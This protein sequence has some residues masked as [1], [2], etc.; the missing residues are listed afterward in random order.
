MPQAATYLPDDKDQIE[1]GINEMRARAADIA[2]AWAYYYGDQTLPLKI[3]PVH[4]DQNVIMNLVGQAADDLVAMMGIPRFEVPGGSA[5]EPDEAGHLR[6]S[7]SDE[8]MW[9]DDWWEAH[10]LAEFMVDLTL[11]GM[12]AGHNYIRLY[13]DGDDGVPQAALLD[14]A[15]VV[16]FWD[17]ANKTRALWYRQQ[18]ATADGGQRMQDIVRGD[19]VRSESGS[20]IAPWVII[21]YA[22]SKNSSRWEW[23]ATDPWEFDFAPIV[24]W[25]NEHKPHHYYGRSDVRTRLNDALN[26]TASSTAKI[27][28]HHAHPKTVVSGQQLPD[29]LANDPDRIIE[30]T[31]PEAKMYNVEMQSDLKSSL[32]FMMTL[33]RAY[34]SEARVVDLASVADKLGQ[35]TNFGV[36]MIFS[37]MIDKVTQKRNL[38]QRGLEDL[39]RRLMVMAGFQVERVNASWPEMLPI[40]RRELVETIEKEQGLGV[41]SKQTASEDLG[42]DFDIELERIEE[43]QMLAGEGL[44]NAL[45]GLTQRGALTG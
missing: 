18:W 9:L 4:G 14:P 23:V 19:L 44:A 34:F 36:R 6:V 31:N 3:S 7:K 30:L 2:K 38:Y 27:L 17:A 42:R 33:R 32:E 25:K 15:L 35:I 8:Q 24:E 16:V 41:V 45:V 29:E 39:S 12:I 11:S 20:T 40:D 21:E 22:M 43:E 10:D 13:F 26:F 1:A 28:R 37:R 5:R